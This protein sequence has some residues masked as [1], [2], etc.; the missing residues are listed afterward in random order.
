MH[1]MDPDLVAGAL[2]TPMEPIPLILRRPTLTPPV[3]DYVPGYG[4]PIEGTEVAIVRDAPQGDV[5]GEGICR[6]LR[7]RTVL[8]RTL[9]SAPTSTP[10]TRAASNRESAPAP[11]ADVRATSVV[12]RTRPFHG[13]DGRGAGRSAV[14]YAICGATIRCSH[15]HVWNRSLK[16][17]PAH[18]AGAN[19]LPRGGQ[20][21][22][23]TW[24]ATMSG[25]TSYVVEI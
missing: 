14:S 10:H 16:P 1:E 22:L 23:C 13:F 8:P 24:S 5:Q 17:H 11:S 19:F 18:V 12:L 4:F 2:E 20:A 25:L 9:Q 21:W 7:R 15:G 6:A 3:P